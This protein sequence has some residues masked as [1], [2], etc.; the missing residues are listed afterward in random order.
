MQDYEEILIKKLIQIVLDGKSVMWVG[1]W[2]KDYKRRIMI[3]YNVTSLWKVSCRVSG[4]FVLGLVSSN[5][6]INYH[7]VELNC[8]GTKFT[9]NIKQGGDDSS[10][11]VRE[12]TQ[13]ELEQLETRTQF[14]EEFWLHFGPQRAI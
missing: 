1:N 5:N 9:D 12:F 7:K 11:R 4:E 8:T 3:N 2:L 10:C 6:S 13:A 14:S